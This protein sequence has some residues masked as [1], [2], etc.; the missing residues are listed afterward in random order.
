MRARRGA[1]VTC[2]VMSVAT[3]LSGC[4]IGGGGGE[5]EAPS[6]NA[7]V[8]ARETGTDWSTKNAV[9]WTDAQRSLDGAAKR[10]SDTYGIELSAYVRV[11]SGPYKGLTA[12]VGEDKKVYSAST[13]K[14][15]LVVTTLIKFGD[16][17]DRIVQVAPENIVGGTGAITWGG[18]YTI[19]TLLR[20][21]MAYSDNAA[22]NTLIDLVGGF[23]AVNKVIAGAGVDSAKYH[24]GN[25]MNIP[26]PT[27]DRSW[28]TPSQAALFTARLQEAADGS[29]AY[30]FIS[31]SA[32]RTALQYLTYGG[33]QK[34][35]AYVGSAAQKTG[36]TE[37]GTNDHGILYTAAGPI[38]FG[39]V[40]RFSSP[41]N[42]LADALLA[43]LGS[44]IAS[45]L[46]DF[47]ALDDNGKPF[48]ASAAASWSEDRDGDGIAYRLGQL[49]DGS[50][51]VD[52][53]DEEL[54]PDWY[55]PFR[56]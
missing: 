46:P 44:E 7:E 36:D 2:A 20:F 37:K 19:E 18:Q 32:A 26:N 28:I 14:A 53:V 47:N 55:N 33:A 43:Q 50:S 49:D 48:S 8:K 42:E 27:G 45:L 15:P 22:A 10:F 9:N 3:L 39:V 6:R 24:L 38:A 12:S 23:D 4:T 17:L 40:T 41:S 1:A 51:P 34:F 30:D 56:G 13:I 31:R 16:N 21:V 11:I 54:Q 25:K 35:A 52:D 29:T 5:G